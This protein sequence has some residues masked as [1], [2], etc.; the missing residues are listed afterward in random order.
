MQ[1]MPPSAS[2][3]GE[4]FLETRLQEMGQRVRAGSACYV[5]F[6]LDNTLFDTRARTAWVAR[7]FDLV[8]DTNHFRSMTLDQVG[9]D[10][11]ET[12]ARMGIVAS[13]LTDAFAQ[14][15]EE[16]F[17]EGSAFPHDTP[18]EPV[19]T[20]ARRAAQTGA[21]VRFLTGRIDALREA[22]VAQLSSVGFDGVTRASLWMKPDLPT[23]TL[24]FK[25]SMLRQSMQRGW[26]GWYATE[27]RDEIAHL[28]RTMPGGPWVLVDCSLQQGGPRVALDTPTLARA[29]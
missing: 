29:F 19:L 20:W 2:V 11:R 25:E 13:E 18:V 28:Q 7:T 14:F 8:N 21:E 24:A 4:Q 10:G 22:T 9:V 17:W 26:L 15:W 23:G 6:D 27:G 12:C 5:V 3:S 16:K 1:D